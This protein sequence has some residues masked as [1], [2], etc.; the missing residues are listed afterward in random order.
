MRKLSLLMLL[1]ACGDDGVRHTPDATVHDAAPDGAPDAPVDANPGAVTLTI[2]HGGSA[3]AGITVYFQNADNSLVLSTTTD[4]NGVASAVMQP[5]GSVT[6]IQPFL[7]LYGRL[8]PD[9]ITT[10]LGVQV[11]D[12]LHLDASTLTTFT[13]NYTGPTSQNAN[14]QSYSVFSPCLDNGVNNQVNL[15]SAGTGQFDLQNCGATTDFLEVAYDGTGTPVEYFRASGVAVSSGGTVDLS[16]QTFTAVT[17]KSFAYTNVPQAYGSPSITESLASLAGRNYITS[18]SGSSTAATRMLVPAFTGA[19]DITD[20]SMFNGTAGM[21]RFIDWG[22]FS[23]TY[24]LDVGARALPDLT[25]APSYMAAT[26]Q[27]TFNEAAGGVT[28]DFARASVD[29][30]RTTDSKSWLWTV[31]SPHATAIT[32]P[33]LPTTPYDYNISANDSINSVDLLIGKVPGGYD[34]VRGHLASFDSLLQL[35]TTLSG[36]MTVEGRVLAFSGKPAVLRHRAR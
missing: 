3:Q 22:P 30:F 21:Q 4:A 17:S 11:G 8:P 18:F 36:S 27:V 10:F 29:V 5:G 32:L 23:A 25:S 12:H 14:V 33:T 26:H 1:V 31:V 24:T 19:I 9:N 20:T 35:I 7:A 28:P 15:G 16:A 6:A 2:T 34:A 13:I